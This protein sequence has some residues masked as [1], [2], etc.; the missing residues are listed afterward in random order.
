MVVRRRRWPLVE[1]VVSIP[2][3]EEEAK[4]T[5]NV[6][7]VDVQN[8]PSVANLVDILLTSC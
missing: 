4:K 5:A 2:E 8:Q 6:M 1:S 7:E 3:S